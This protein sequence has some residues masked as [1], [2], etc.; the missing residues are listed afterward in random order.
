[1]SI[2]IVEDDIAQIIEKE[3]QEKKLPKDKSKETYDDA[4]K[5]YDYA[6]KILESIKRER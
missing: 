3:E 5:S 4:I 1:M 2:G 6:T